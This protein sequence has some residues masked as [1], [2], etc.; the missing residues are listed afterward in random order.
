MKKFFKIFKI[1]LTVVFTGYSI[2]II[3]SLFFSDKE[4]RYEFASHMQGVYLS[5]SI[6]EILKFQDPENSEIYFEQSVPFNKRGDY[7]RG[8][9]L[10]DKAV[11][12]NPRIYLGYRGYL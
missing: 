2:L 3:S 10:L 1:L 8:F 12:N 4:K 11:D 6:F 5:Q 7:K 9:E